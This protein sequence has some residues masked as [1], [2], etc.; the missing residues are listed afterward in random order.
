M[1]GIGIGQLDGVGVTMA[2]ASISTSDRRSR[3]LWTTLRSPTPPLLVTLLLMLLMMFVVSVSGLVGVA[4]DSEATV[5]DAAAQ[6]QHQQSN[7]DGTAFGTVRV[8]N[9][10]RLFRERLNE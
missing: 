7:G 3:F 9:D 6:Q 2:A 5:A 1:V 10:P 4:D 8:A